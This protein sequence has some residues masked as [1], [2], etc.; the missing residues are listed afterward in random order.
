MRGVT[1]LLA[2]AMAPLV[3]AHMIMVDP[4]SLRY[5]GNKNSKTADYN[6]RSPLEQTGVDFP[7][8]GHLTA[9]GTPEGASVASWAA[10]S[11][12]SF[13]VVGTAFH[14]GG[15]CQASF[16]EDGGK[17]FKVVKSFIG[18]C[19]S[20][21]GN[22]SYPFTVPAS[23]KAGPTIFAWTW[24]NRFGNREM[25]MNCAAVTITG[26]GGSGLASLPEIFKAN[27]GNGCATIPDFAL[28]I[29]NPGEDIVK[30][31]EKLVGPNCTTTIPDAGPQ[32]GPPDGVGASATP[33]APSLITGVPPKHSTAPSAPASISTNPSINTTSPPGVGS[34]KITPPQGSA[35]ATE[36]PRVPSSYA[37]APSEAPAAPSAPAII[38][39][40]LGINT[41]KPPNI[42]GPG[43]SIPTSASCT[44][45]T[46]PSGPGPSNGAGGSGPGS[47]YG[48]SDSNP[49][50]TPTT[51]QTGGPLVPTPSE[52]FTSITNLGCRCECN[53][54]VFSITET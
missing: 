8:K 54:R 35:V 25:Y 5:S 36:P 42:P 38:S 46:T 18:G 43:S 26:S 39:P 22:T 4:P 28:D 19:P 53:G 17:T 7:C 51:M 37:P 23:A 29:P 11:Q 15:S 32:P 34:T 41:T 50:G 9:M 52:T 6:Y 48:S 27:I 24:F 12:Q 47:D 45:S 10:G 20:G 49:A 16:S 2:M 31:G 40:G 13:S 44:Y 14:G 30:T 21:S 3:V 1:Q 33:A